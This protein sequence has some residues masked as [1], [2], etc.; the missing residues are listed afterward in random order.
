MFV[1][2]TCARQQLAQESCGPVNVR[3]LC[4]RC[5]C[6]RASSLWRSPASCSNQTS[7]S[8]RIGTQK[9][10]HKQH[11]WK[12]GEHGCPAICRALGFH[13]SSLRFTQYVAGNVRA[14]Q[15]WLRKT[16]V[17]TLQRAPPACLKGLQPNMS[18]YGPA[19]RAW[20]RL[21]ARQQQ[22]QGGQG[23]KCCDELPK[24]VGLGFS[25]FQCCPSL[26]S[27][28]LQAPLTE[29]HTTGYGKRVDSAGW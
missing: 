2:D 21:R 10:M 15:W 12:D 11:A 24:C 5:Y 19:G 25:S 23:P 18:P 13:E 3:A 9:K 22:L 29:P 6:L 14:C 28:T 7:L 4:G 26:I 8:G 16:R 17:R 1:A 27:C 20:R